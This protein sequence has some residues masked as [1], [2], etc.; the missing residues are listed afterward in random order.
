MGYQQD[1]ERRIDVF[2]DTLYYCEGNRNLLEA[3]QQTRNNTILYQHPLKECTGVYGRR[4]NH[5]FKVFISHTR[6]LEAAKRRSSEYKDSRI[7]MVNFASAVNPGGGVIKGRDTQEE[8]L[9][10]CTTLYPCLCTTRLI[11]EYYSNNRMEGNQLYIDACIFTPGIICIKTDTEYPRLVPEQEWFMV[12]VIS[13]SV[14]N[15]GGNL[16][17]TVSL[18]AE[19][20]LFMEEFKRIEILTKQIRGILQ[21]AADNRIDIL[22]LGVLN[23]NVFC[24]SSNMILDIL[25]KS[26]KEY[27]YSFK[28][29]EL[30]LS[31]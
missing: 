8:S 28:A 1:R 10:R 13:C 30:A 18:P 26:L 9:C 19:T 27:E 24:D 2:E 22:I 7:G 4:Y 5:P 25:K 23:N 31:F 3:I 21:V 6:I 16:K 12:D 20:G 17:N 15:P 11:E 14:A 29:V